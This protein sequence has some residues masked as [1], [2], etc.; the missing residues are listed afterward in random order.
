MNY[1][2]LFDGIGSVHQAFQPLGFSCVGISEV[3]KYCNLLIDKKYG[4][5]NFGDFTNWKNWG[6]INTDVIVASPPC[7]AFSFIGRRRG[8]ADPAGA[9][10]ESCVRFICSQRPQWFVLE[11][12][13]GIFTINEGRLFRWML[14]QFSQCGYN[15]SWR[16]LNAESFGVAQRR[17]RMFL[18]GHFGNGYRAAK[19]LLDGESI[20]IPTQK[21][22]RARQ[23][24]LR[25]I[26]VDFRKDRYW[27]NRKVTATL[28]ASPGG[29]VERIGSV[30]LDKD[31]PRWLTPLERER[32]MGFEDGYTAGFSDTQRHRMTGNSI[33]VPILKWIGERIL[34]TNE[35]IDKK[36]LTG[37]I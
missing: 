16:V 2:S 29:G 1:I 15:C 8:T 32:L 35:R 30:V 26:E 22:E 28:L 36:T 25:A 17:R 11:N 6:R 4:F 9:L 12:V 13:P 7:T 14:N 18:V 37:R 34:A 21:S 33:V 3:N 20:P 10:S 31:R 19:V 5:K 23:N 24:D 27:N